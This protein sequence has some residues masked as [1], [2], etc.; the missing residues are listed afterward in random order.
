MDQPAY[1]A[2][3]L[4]VFILIF[5]A[6][7]TTSLFLFKGILDYS[8]K[9]YDASNQF[10]GE[11]VLSLTGVEAT[12]KYNIIR[13]KD[14]LA[15]VTNFGCYDYDGKTYIYSKKYVED[16]DLNVKVTLKDLSGN[17]TKDVKLNGYY[18]LNIIKQYT[19]SSISV[20]LYQY[21]QQNAMSML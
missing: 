21:T 9:V 16:K 2:L 7:V 20:E 18:K 19:D 8:D 15:Y 10:I 1:D 11:S 14:A 3:F 4:G 5:I 6:A 12:N 17:P 13:G